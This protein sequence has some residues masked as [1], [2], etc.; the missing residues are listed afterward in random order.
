MEDKQHA[1]K[2]NG[3]IGE[4][5]EFKDTAKPQLRDHGAEIS[6]LKEHYASI[7]TSFKIIL[8]LLSILIGG[9]FLIVIKVYTGF[10]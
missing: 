9:V 6:E 4:L 10:G 7:N 8:G 1:C 3:F 2:H 5:R